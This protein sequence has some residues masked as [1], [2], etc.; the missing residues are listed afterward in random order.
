MVSSENFSEGF[1]G[2]LTAEIVD[3]IF[4]EVDDTADL[5][6]LMTT[7]QRHWDIGRRHLER[8]IINDFSMA[9]W[10]GNRLICLGDYVGP[11][12]LP[13]G[14]LTKREVKKIQNLFMC[15]NYSLWRAMYAFQPSGRGSSYKPLG[16]SRG[17]RSGTDFLRKLKARYDASESGSALEWLADT[18]TGVALGKLIRIENMSFEKFSQGHMVFRDLTIKEYV[19]GDIWNMPGDS[20]FTGKRLRFE[21]VLYIR[22]FWAISPNTNEYQCPVDNHRGAWAGH[23]FDVSDINNV[24]DEDGIAVD[25]WKDVTLE[26]MREVL[27]VLRFEI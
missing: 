16:A 5:L 10:A 27:E 8:V 1:F 6:S 12:E 7:C 24:V 3:K 13:K 18:H 4:G 20:R 2:Q 23:R 21:H 26:V 25:G 17:L 14:M 19:R 11:G 9:S 15:N 22:I